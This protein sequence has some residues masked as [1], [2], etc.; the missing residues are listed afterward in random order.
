M[1]VGFDKLPL[2]TGGTILDPVTVQFALEVDPNEKAYWLEEKNVQ[3]KDYTGH[4]RYQFIWVQRNGNL[5]VFIKDLGPADE[6]MSQFLIP[7][8]WE[9]SIAELSDLA[10]MMREDATEGLNKVLKEAQESSTLID[11][12]IAYAEARQAARQKKTVFGAGQTS[13]T[14]ERNN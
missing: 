2:P 14:F 13:A 7:S 8:D 11:D 5:A 3:A 10:L 12:T 9:H 6:N 4:R 1:A